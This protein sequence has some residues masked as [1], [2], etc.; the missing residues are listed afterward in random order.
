[1]NAAGRGADLVRSFEVQ[2]W[3]RRDEAS[4]KVRI[5][6]KT[7]RFVYRKLKREE[8]NALESEKCALRRD[9]SHSHWRNKERK[10]RGRRKGERQK[11]KE[12]RKETNKEIKWMKERKKEN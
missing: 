5:V 2:L 1:M 12:R 9:I 11:I 6:G 7:E 3:M 4:K 10:V 8:I